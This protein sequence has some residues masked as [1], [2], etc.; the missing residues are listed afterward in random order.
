M[1]VYKLKC[2]N[3]HEFDGWFKNIDSFEE[4]IAGKNVCC[5]VC[6]DTVLEKVLASN[7][8]LKSLESLQENKKTVGD[9]NNAYIMLKN[10]SDKIKKEFEYV[11]E[12]FSQ[13]ARKIHYGEAKKRNIYGK[14]DENDEKAL[15]V[16]GIEYFKLPIIR[17]TD[18]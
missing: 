3:S 9:S 14:T 4:Q 18:D 6:A 16:E 1:I 2:S 5:P 10:I 15:I 8:S 11:G 12:K 17:E 13:E 7:Q